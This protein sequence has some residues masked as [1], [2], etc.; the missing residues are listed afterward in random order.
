MMEH[1][2][3]MEWNHAV[4]AIPT[5]WIDGKERSP[6]RGVLKHLLRIS[7]VELDIILNDSA[8]PAPRVM[9]VIR[10]IAGPHGRTW[11]KLWLQD[12]P[13]ASELMWP[14]ETPVFASGDV[15]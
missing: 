6:R 7:E 15:K 12:Y 13:A 8:M 3:Y 14:D 5:A 11:M 4:D 10:M 9:R 1:D 2:W